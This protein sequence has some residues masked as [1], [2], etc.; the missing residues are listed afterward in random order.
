MECKD[1]IERS[2]SLIK[3]LLSPLKDKGYYFHNWDHTKEVFENAK[4]Y[5]TKLNFS[6]EDTCKLLLAALFHDVGFLVRYDG[7]E[8]AS[9]QIAKEFLKG[10]IHPQWIKQIMDMI[11]ATKI[12]VQPKNL[13]E[14]ALK[15][16]DV[17][18]IRRE[19]FLQKSDLLKRELETLFGV[20]FSK[21]QWLKRLEDVLEI[22]K[23]YTWVCEELKQE[24][25][26]NNASL[27]QLL[28]NA[29]TKN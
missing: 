10:Q 9:A 22:G 8:E 14:A 23:C 27:V 4:F 24:W 26:K 25:L 6:Y 2:Y 20:K 18:N 3:T 28:K 15:D 13:L 29:N 16:S 7:H 19:D 11:R 12:G 5:A 21:Q 1:V 17:D